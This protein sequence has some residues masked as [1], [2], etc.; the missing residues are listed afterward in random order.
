[1]CVIGCADVDCD[2]FYASVEELDRPE[3]KFEYPMFEADVDI[4]PWV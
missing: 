4:F 3:L 2:A 1:M